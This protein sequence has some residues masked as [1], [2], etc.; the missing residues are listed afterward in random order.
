[1]LLALLGG[2]PSPDWRSPTRS[3]ISP[4]LASAH[5]KKLVAGGLVQVEPKGR[6]RMYSIASAVVADALESLI[7]LAPPS[8]AR[9]LREVN[10][11]AGLRRARLCYDHLAGVLGVGVT[12]ALL[13]RELIGDRDGSFVLT[14]AGE[15]AFDEF[16]CDV[17]SLERKRRPLVR[18]CM[19]WS[20]RRP[21]LAGS[22]GAALTSE[23]VRRDW[24]R[25]KEASRV[26]TLTHAGAAGLESWLGLDLAAAGLK[27]AA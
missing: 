1:M 10:K 24:V 23:L 2:S 22:L 7:L 20:E 12:E 18:A 3:E 8:E 11:S 4:A 26:V 15:K 6:H 16:G 17:G 9:S 14:R 19:D 13:D 5:L 25:T 21:H 27:A